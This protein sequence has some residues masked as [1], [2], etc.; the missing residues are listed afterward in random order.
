[1]KLDAV[2]EAIIAALQQDGRQSNREIARCLNVSEG[3][4]RQR[5][6]KLA[7]A[8]AV[9]FDVVVDLTQMGIAFVAFVRA[10]VSPRHLEAFLDACADQPDI[11]YVAAVAGRFNV[12]A[13]ICARTAEDGLRLI[14]SR[15]ETLKGVIDIEVRQVVG[16]KKHDFR[17]T[18][19]AK[20]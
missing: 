10:A 9:A 14:N 15:V 8:G 18:V 7:D 6:K 1:M 19:V 12:L 16:F 20:R 11:F 4:V 2:D 3:T 13:L 5:L 17:E